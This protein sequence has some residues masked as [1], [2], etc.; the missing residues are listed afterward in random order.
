MELR[1]LR[2]EFRSRLALLYLPEEIDA[3]FYRLIHHISGLPRHILGIEPL[4][5]ISDSEAAA[6][7]SAL[8]QLQTGVPLQ[9]I[10]GIAYFMDQEFEVGPG[11]LIPR[12]ETEELVRWIWESFPESEVLKILDVGTGSGCIPLSLGRL[13][14][15][16]ELHAMDK[17]S[18][19]LAY[20]KRNSKKHS[21]QVYWYEQDLFA[22]HDFNIQFDIMVSNPPY[23]PEA[24][25]S[26]IHVNVRDF[27][28][29]T[30]LFVPDNDPLKFYRQLVQNSTSWI[31]PG[32]WLY[33]EIHENFSDQVLALLKEAGMQQ[34]QLKMDIFG[35]PRFVRGQR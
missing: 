35:K 26:K 6:L 32:G 18:E 11:V 28:P 20:A 1:S 5:V 14:S 30:A 34:V 13:F 4:K 12:P 33:L 8:V 24:E 31:K 3:L 22:V 10:T 9:Y 27:E 23:I 19:A 7:E 16:A 2:H 25:A 17:S 15:N 29:V 21:I